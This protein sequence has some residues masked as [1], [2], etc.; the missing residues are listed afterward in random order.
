MK[1]YNDTPEQ[2]EAASKALLSRSI[3]LMEHGD[4]SL[5]DAIW[6]NLGFHGAATR[7]AAAGVLIPLGP[8]AQAY[9]ALVCAAAEHVKAQ[10]LLEPALDA[11]PESASEN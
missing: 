9:I 8:H 7:L 2:C 10:E 3:E 4:G 5:G 1:P 6:N 11:E